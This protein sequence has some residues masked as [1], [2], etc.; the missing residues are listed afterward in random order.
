MNFIKTISETLLGK[1][2]Q[3]IEEKKERFEVLEKSENKEL[4]IVEP[5]EKETIIKPEVVETIIK[6]IEE[7]VIQPVVNLEREQTEIREVIQ[8]I[9]KR[10]I[11]PTSVEEKELPTIEKEEIRE[12]SA[13]F[14]REYSQLTSNFQNS[15]QVEKLQRKT[16]TNAP[17]VKET[18]HKR[19]IEEIQ[20][21]VHKETI[22]PRLVKSTQPIHEKIIEAPKLVKEDFDSKTDLEKL[23]KEGVEVESYTKTSILEETIKPIEKTEIQPIINLDREQTEIHEVIQPIRERKI[24]PISVE[25]KNLPTVEKEAVRESTDQFDKQYAQLTSTFKDSLQVEHIQKKT[26]TNAP[27]VKETIH[28]KIIEEIQPIIHK[29]TIVPHLI[30]ENLV[31]H[32]K[33]VEAPVLV[34][35]VLPEK[36]LG[37]VTFEADRTVLESL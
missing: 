7:I 36:D 14:D 26:V 28:K 34:K 13:A 37:T 18:V 22:A 16:V 24:M 29:E 9:R 32:E 8:P 6:P 1:D 3:S 17:I 2:T 23:K 20:P 11:L 5:T 15:T 33:L 30:K 25:E 19:I 21:V 31:I 35:E 4:T 10:E 12:S 27:I